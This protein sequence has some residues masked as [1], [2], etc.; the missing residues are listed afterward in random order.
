LG[1]RATGRVL[2]VGRAETRIFH[3]ADSR[4]FAAR[5]A[6]QL[7]GAAAALAERRFPDG[8]SLVRV[9]G[10]V[11]RRAVLVRGLDDPNRKLVEVLLAADAMR[12]AGAARVTLVAP[13]LGYMRQDAVF[14]P[15]EP[16]SQMVVGRLLAEAF[17][18][19]LTVE[20]HLHRV[21]SLAGVAGPGARSLS[22]A[23]EIRRW[24][25]QHASGALVVGPDVESTPWVRAIAT[26]AD[27]PWVVGRKLRHGDRRV[28]IEFDGVPAVRRAVIVD[29]IASSGATLAVAARRLRRH[30]IRS[31][32]ALVVHAIFAPGAAERI[33]LAG[34]RRIVSSDTIVHRSNAFSVAGVI[35]AA[36]APRR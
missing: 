35:A 21:D 15:G 22:A 9:P 32:D 28:T 19:V 16:N 14:A 34:V 6:A 31:I 27:L 5:L 12:R 3:F 25:E 33:R 7:G 26:A 30:G 18:E 4:R 10:A 29:D 23:D 8:E 24:I 1:L 20:A 17:D 13:Y 2:G 11:S 36:L